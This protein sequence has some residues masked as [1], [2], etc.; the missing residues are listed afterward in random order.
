MGIDSMNITC[1]TDIIEI[2]RIRESIES[3]GDKFLR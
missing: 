2:G 1:G 3:L